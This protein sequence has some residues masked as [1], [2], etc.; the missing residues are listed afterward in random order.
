FGRGFGTLVS[1]G[2]ES[3]LR[4]AE[5]LIEE[6]AFLE[7]EMNLLQLRQQDDAGLAA[8]AVE[9]LARLMIRKGLLEDAAYYFR[10]LG[11]DYATTVI[12]DGKTG[13]DL[14][15]EQATDKRFLPYLD[16]PSAPWIGRRVSAK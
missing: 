9:D 8:R 15:N 10:I 7:A 13:A 3:R 14:F 12:R 1:V 11:R 4:L 5:R 16:E 2:K 6:D